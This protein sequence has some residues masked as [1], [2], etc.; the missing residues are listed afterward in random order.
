MFYIEPI[1]GEKMEQLDTNMFQFPVE[2]T[3]SSPWLCLK[4]KKKSVRNLV[5]NEGMNAQYTNVK[6]DS[7]IPY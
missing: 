1:M 7:L 3:N 5:G 4:S 2:T 6:V